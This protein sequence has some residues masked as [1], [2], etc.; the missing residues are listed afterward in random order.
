MTQYTVI[1]VTSSTQAFNIPDPSTIGTTT[2]TLVKLHEQDEHTKVNFVAKVIE[3]K[4][5]TT[6]TT[7]KIKQDIV[8]ADSTGDG[9]LTLWEEHVGKLEQ[10]KTYSFKKLDVRVFQD[11]CTLANTATCLNNDTCKRHRHSNT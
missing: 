1:T 3:V 4:P 9:I 10:Q 11:E 2:I 7:G 6:V 5:H 8:L